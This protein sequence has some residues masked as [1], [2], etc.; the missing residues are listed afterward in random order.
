M[1]ALGH[2]RQVG[3]N[4]SVTAAGGINIAQAEVLGAAACLRHVSRGFL[5]RNLRKLNN[6]PFHHQLSSN[7]P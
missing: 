5:L 1:L 3:T 4:G 2:S 7:V 6:I